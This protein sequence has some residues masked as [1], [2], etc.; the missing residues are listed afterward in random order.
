MSLRTGG[1]V[2]FRAIFASAKEAENPLPQA[3]LF[4]FGWCGIARFTGI[5]RRMVVV[6]LT[7]TSRATP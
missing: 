5:A 1:A 3:F 7:A 4:R 6:A 2:G